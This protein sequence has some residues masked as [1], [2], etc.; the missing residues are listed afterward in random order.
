MG[1]FII[2]KFFFYVI[3]ECGRNNMRFIG[4]FY[5]FEVIGWE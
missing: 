2:V 4:I 5:G 3:E 1:F